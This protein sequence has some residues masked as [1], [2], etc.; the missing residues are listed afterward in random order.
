MN[1]VRIPFRVIMSLA[2]LLSLSLSALPT[3]S[4]QAAPP[5]PRIN[6]SHCYRDFGFPF[7]CATVQVPLDY[8]DPGAASIGIAIVRL[9]ASDPA[10]KIGSLF[11]NP[12]G[13]GGSGVDFLLFAGPF[14]YTDEVRARFDLIGFDPLGI[15]RSTALRCFGKGR[16][17]QTCCDRSRRPKRRQVG[18]LQIGAPLAIDNR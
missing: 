12:G 5:V 10:N 17:S 4:S 18:A 13:P 3:S 2:I 9:P 6:W 14:L 11:F 1:S 16:F 8:S 7:E 15:A